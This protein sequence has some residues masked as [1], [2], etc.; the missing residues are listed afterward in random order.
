MAKN[1]MDAIKVIPHPRDDGILM[2]ASITLSV[3]KIYNCQH[4]ENQLEKQGGVPAQ[5]SYHEESEAD[6]KRELMSKIRVM[7]L[8]GKTDGLWLNE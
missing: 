2:V 5:F 3:H 8:T 4:W 1:L 6:I 7:M